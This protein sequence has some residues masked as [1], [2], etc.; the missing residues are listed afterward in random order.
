M[1]TA[2][3]GPYQAKLFGLTLQELLDQ[4]HYD[5]VFFSVLWDAPHFV[6]LAFS[7]V[8]E[9]KIGSS[10]DFIQRLVKRSSIVHQIFQRGKMLKRAMEMET[11]DDELVLK[12]TSR[13]C[14]TRFITSQYVEFKKLLA[15]LPLF[16]KTFRKFQSCEIKE[17]MIAGE[18]FV[19]DLCG[20]VDILHPM[21]DMFVELQSLSA[22]C[23]KVIT[24]WSNLKE[25]IEQMQADFSLTAPPSTFPMLEANIDEIQSGTYKGTPSGAWV[26]GR[27][28][29]ESR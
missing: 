29:R 10:K 23:W 25:H 12:L 13:G 24:W 8:F 15:S 5:P 14:S 26:D 6:D 4:T 19:M 1:G 18:D 2:C 9:G 22:P 7:D 11:S 27:F 20:V 28:M 21:I 17:Y 3:D 16:V